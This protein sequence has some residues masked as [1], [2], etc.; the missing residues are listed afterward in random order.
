MLR[1]ACG[2]DKG[3]LRGTNEDSMLCMDS[4]GFYMVADGVGGHNSGEI[5]SRLAVDLMKTHLLANP[6]D[7]IKESDLPDFFNRC[8]WQI[9]E[10]IYKRASS[11]VGNIG[12]ATTAV[13]LLLRGKKA[14]I[15][16]VGDSRAYLYRQG[17]LTRITEDHTY[18][19]ELLK[20]G[21]ISEYEAEVHPKRNIITR[22]FGSE[23]TIA[24]DFYQFDVTVGDRI[25][26]CTD[27]LYNEVAE[28]QIREL[29]HRERDL[30]KLV[31]SLIHSACDNGGKDN[32]T[33]ICVET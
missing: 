31:M 13:M 19:N 14:Y 29:T 9:N 4:L 6:P 18:V 8:L 25:L 30:E 17:V 27:G 32:I 7:R 15:F 24:P 16:N 2:T 1:S 10:E 11:D 3:K 5:A 22:A 21:R 23:E 33:V 20:S 26:L 12:M 28:E